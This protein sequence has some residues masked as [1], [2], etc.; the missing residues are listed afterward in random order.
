MSAVAEDD[1]KEQAENDLVTG[2][3][4]LLEKERAALAKREIALQKKELEM[5]ERLELLE[6]REKNLSMLDDLDGLTRDDINLEDDEEPAQI[7][8]ASSLQ[9]PTGKGPGPKDKENQSED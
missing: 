6:V 8:P 7:P 9:R 4:D 2:K 1:E 3:E 5:I